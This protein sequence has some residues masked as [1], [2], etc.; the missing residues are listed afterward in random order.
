M[1]CAKRLAAAI[2]EADGLSNPELLEKEFGAE[3]KLIK[4]TR[5]AIAHSY[6]FVDAPLIR[7]T[8]NRDLASFEAGI[9]RIAI[10]LEDQ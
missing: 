8:V 1:P 2:E 4:A 3:W 10:K 7:S 5:N 6:A 9:S